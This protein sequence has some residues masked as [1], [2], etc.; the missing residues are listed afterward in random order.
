MKPLIQAHR[1]A[2]LKALQSG[3]EDLRDRFENMR[4]FTDQEPRNS[5]QACYEYDV[6]ALSA[7][8]M[9]AIGE[10]LEA[11]LHNDGP[12]H[13]IDAFPIRLLIRV[14]NKN[15]PPRTERPPDQPNNK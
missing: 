6:S 15:L 11:V 9:K 10:V 14:W 7:A 13:K 2:I 4:R 3:P 1:N 5:V 8:E 12:K